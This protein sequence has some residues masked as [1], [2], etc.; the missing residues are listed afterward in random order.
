MKRSLVLSVA[1]L[2]FFSGMIVGRLVLPT[3]S[4][5][6]EG[7]KA[8]VQ[9]LETNSS[10]IPQP[11][12]VGSADSTMSYLSAA[13]RGSPGEKRQVTFGSRA[14]MTSDLH[15]KELDSMLNI[16]K[17]DIQEPSNTVMQE[18][19]EEQL[20]EE[21]RTSLRDDGVSSAHEIDTV[22]H[23]LFIAKPMPGDIKSLGH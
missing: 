7:S 8:E 22:I 9:P 20:K 16:Q 11:S 2:I 15:Q 1:A 4:G 12:W 18:I 14:L 10:R 19:S 21:F 5:R 23:S 3:P 13:R 6:N 17:D